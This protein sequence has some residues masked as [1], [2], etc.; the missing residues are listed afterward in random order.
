[1]LIVAGSIFAQ[2]EVKIG[3][4]SFRSKTQTQ[5]QW[6]PLE[7]A[8]NKAIPEHDFKIVAYDLDE[9]AA[10]VDSRQ[11]DFIL[12]NPGHY[13]LMAHRSGLSAPLATLSNLEQGKPVSSFGGVIITRAD[14]LEINTIKDLRGKTVAASSMDS[15]GSYEMQALELIHAGIRMPQDIQLKLT[16]FPQDG[17]VTAVLTNHADAGFVRSGLLESLASEGKLDLSEIKIL[18]RQNLSY[19]PA[20][21]STPL[22]PE[23]PFA[24]L[25]HTNRDLK[26]KVA[27]FL[28]TVEE[29]KP[30][31]K[32]LGIHGFDVPADYESVENIL[33]ELRM[34]PFDFAPAFTILDVWNRYRWP[35]ALGMVAIVLILLLASNLFLAIRRLV[36]EKSLVQIQS[37]LLQHSNQRF[38][39]VLRAVPD[40]MFELDSKG[41]YLNVWGI[42]GDLLA[43]PENQLIGHTVEEILPEDASQIVKAS[44]AEAAEKNS[45]FGRE[46]KLQLPQGLSWFEL[47]VSKRQP[48]S[49]ENASFIVLSRDITSRKE[50]EEKIEL[51][52]YYD[53]L[54]HLPNRRLLLDRLQ[55]ELAS[56]VRSGKL[57]ALLFI[58][59]DNFKTLNDTLGH[60]VGDFLLQKVA[61]RLTTCVREGDTVS[62]LGGDEFVIMLNDL[63]EVELEAAA[64][65]EVIGHKILS[66]LNRPYQLD[67][68]AYH[69]TPSIGATLF[70]KRKSAIEEI[71]KQADIAMYQAKNAGRN[72]FRFFDVNM[73]VAINDRVELED[74]LRSAI[75]LK[76]FVLHYQIQV[77]N[78]QRPIGAEALI[79]WLHP[80]MGL[81]SPLKFIPLAEETGLILPI[82]Q[83]VL[84]TACA[85]LKFWQNNVLTQHLTL[86]VNVS[87]KQFHEANFISQ[88]QSAVSRYEINP[89]RLKLEPTESILLE[90]I[91]EAV[92]TMTTLK[93]I[94]VHFALDD[95]GTG[96]S[97]LQYLKMLP[98]NQLKIDQSFV[99]DL[100]SDLNDQAIVK[101]IIAMAKSLNLDVIAEGVETEE[102]QQILQ[103]NG[104]NA[105]QGYF[106]GKP[107][108]IEQFEKQLELH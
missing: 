30:L 39:A 107:M 60:D 63:S 85:Q 88:V 46:F 59:L 32:S 98:L 72:T 104:C 96:F 64:Q 76:Q 79:R 73:Q 83:W 4:L 56:N 26:R 43:A 95:F 25:P 62:R 58:D 35:I 17:V 75:E 57:G 105:Y 6:T 86:S 102:Q 67:A 93:A 91:K 101:T 12:T 66:A 27:S 44:L 52:A 54:T 34:P 48:E 77:D 11:V 21:V 69:N 23:W 65:T 18:N 40:L 2:E 15:L 19:F 50:A 31:A 13:V 53:P 94:G 10:A 81:V 28:L 68:R 106:F 61:E 99:R 92:S 87:A 36:S 37:V 55:Q 42:R 108:P 78:F 24:S 5:T 3:I 90:N 38:E 8:L 20:H 84:E 33:R 1:L 7:A 70:G 41:R 45:S 9:M 14:K 103:R 100:V 97:S 47:S 89:A 82:G 80:E 22:Y 29:N 49:A 71:L 16:G 51:L 74:A